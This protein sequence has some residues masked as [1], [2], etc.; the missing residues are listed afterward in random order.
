METIIDLKAAVNFLLAN[1]YLTVV[2]NKLVITNKLHRETK[3][4][5]KDR[6]DVL[7]PDEP[8]II[9]REA[10]WAKFIKDADIPYQVEGSEGRKY[11]V[12]QYSDGIVDDLVKIIKSC[13]YNILV[14]SVKRY[15]NSN[16]YK[17]LLS[18]YIR[19]GIWKDEYER[20]KEAIK[21]ST[22]AYGQ[23]GNIWET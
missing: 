19:K 20:Y 8:G 6:V 17:L 21:T 10:I 5:P 11:T 15:Y 22:V 13:D 12:R 14:G 4:A 9:T 2:E 18:N 1:D 3:L 23:G 16:T 7:F